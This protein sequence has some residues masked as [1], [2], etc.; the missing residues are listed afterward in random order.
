MS[1][2]SDPQYKHPF[3]LF[4][5]YV[6]SFRIRNRYYFI[7]LLS[8]SI[9]HCAGL[10]FSGY[11]KDGKAS[12]DLIR[13]LYI[14]EIEFATSVRSILHGWNSMTSKWLRR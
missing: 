3:R 2:L 8:E 10:G 4:L 9:N 12:W 1:S 7:W 14:M 5:N 13:N 11:D 6:N